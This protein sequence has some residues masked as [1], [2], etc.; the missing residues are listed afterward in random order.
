VNLVLKRALGERW[1]RW[2]RDFV[3]PQSF[4]EEKDYH[5]NPLGVRVYTGY[6]AEFDLKIME[7]KTKLTLLVDTKA[8]VEQSA[9]IHDALMDFNKSGHWEKREKEGAIRYLEGTSVLTSYDKK[10]YLVY[11]VDFSATCA[12]KMIGDLGISHKEYFQKNKKV[13]I[14]FPND[15]LIESKGR[16]NMPIF[17]PPELL[18]TTALPQEFKAKLPQ[19]AGLLPDQRTPK[20]QNFVRF[21]EPGAQKTKGLEG[22]LPGIGI[23]L[24]SNQIPVPVFH[25]SVPFLKAR[26]I[27][28]FFS[29]LSNF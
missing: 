19:I 14:H 15:P 24:S 16:N 6:I 3:D 22:L 29:F 23:R 18:H 9:T 2:G 28:V 27:Q 17:L 8:K 12:T 7:G 11:G 10:N 5:G 1:P 20:L 21:L 25:L 13:E 4:R 26:G